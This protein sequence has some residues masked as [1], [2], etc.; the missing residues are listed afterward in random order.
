MHQCV[1]PPEGPAAIAVMSRHCEP[2]E[3]WRLDAPGSSAAFHRAM[4]AVRLVSRHSWDLVKRIVACVA[5]FM[6][7]GALAT[8]LA[9][10]AILAGCGANRTNGGAA[11]RAVSPR[12]RAFGAQLA[13]FCSAAVTAE[14]GGWTE[15]GIVA[16][17]RRLMA[18]VPPPSERILYARLIANMDKAIQD[19]RSGDFVA[20]RELGVQIRAE[21]IQL[22]APSCTKSLYKGKGI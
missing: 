2:H 13:A 20:A 19:I 8:A 22:H 11:T 16:V 14:R 10:S 12:E 5:S 3:R 18:L 17:G 4:P 21:V 6:P 7:R 9:V 15:A 1:R